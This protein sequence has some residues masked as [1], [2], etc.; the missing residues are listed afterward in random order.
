MPAKVFLE[1]FVEPVLFLAVDLQVIVEGPG[2]DQVEVA[3]GQ[4]YTAAGGERQQQG[5][6]H[7]GAGQPAR[8]ERVLA[9]A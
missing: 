8:H 9:K 3:V 2:D 6:E 7:G 4:A 1:A 5:D